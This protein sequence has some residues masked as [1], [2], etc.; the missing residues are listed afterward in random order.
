[1]IKGM[2]LIFI[3]GPPASGKQTI[4]EEIAR[5][6]GYKLFHNNLTQDVA[7]EIYPAFDEVRFGLADKLRLATFEY[8]A[9]HGTDLIFTFVY[10]GDSDDNKFVADTN[11]TITKNGGKVLFVQLEAP[12]NVLLER[13]NNDSRNR[14]HKLTDAKVLGDKLTSK[15]YQ[16]SVSKFDVYR[17]D[18]TK[19]E[20]AESAELILKHYNLKSL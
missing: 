7:R 4:G 19:Q 12:D 2:N 1:M 18:T 13:V 15:I 11:D 5:Q 20:P 16:A 14:F 10:T 9:Q 3:Y 8:A 6:N 17:L